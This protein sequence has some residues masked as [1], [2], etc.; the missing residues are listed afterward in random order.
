MFNMN[1][2]ALNKSSWQLGNLL[3]GESDCLEAWVE[4]SDTGRVTRAIGLI[5][6]GAGLYGG[7]MGCWRAKPS[8]FRLP[9]VSADHPIDHFG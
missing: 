5:V 1:G 9:Q 8:P 3:R 4:K 6:L 7:A 2:E